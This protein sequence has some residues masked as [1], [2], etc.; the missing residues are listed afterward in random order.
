MS[1]VAVDKSQMLP[2]AKTK[3]P[4]SLAWLMTYVIADISDVVDAATAAGA[5]LLL[6]LLMS[7]VM[8]VRL[9]L[10]MMHAAQYR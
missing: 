10:R 7:L 3:A 9:L 5:T 8:Q 4:S 6:L 1:R 2:T